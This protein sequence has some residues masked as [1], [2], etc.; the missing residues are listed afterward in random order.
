MDG[1]P[2]LWI[3]RRQVTNGKDEI[4]VNNAMILQ[5][6]SN[7][8]QRNNFGSKQVLHVIDS[9]LEPIWSTSGQIYNPDAFQFLNQS[10][11]LDL[12]QHRV[13]YVYN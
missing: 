7:Y 4:F 3:T 13:R 1:N 5:S 8:E 11:N 6:R 12:G 10:E 2:P 9:V